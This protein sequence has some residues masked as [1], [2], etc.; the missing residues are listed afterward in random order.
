MTTATVEINNDIALNLLQYL[1]NIGM[2]RLLQKTP[3][4]KAQKL[5]DRFSGSLSKE[6]VSYMQKEL[7][8]VR[9]EWERNI[10]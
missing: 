4:A 3:V 7:N 6:R 2:L 5:S 1:E 9:N 8:S 10:F